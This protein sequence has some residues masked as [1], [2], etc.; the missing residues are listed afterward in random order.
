MSIAAA[1]MTALGGFLGVIGI[2]LLWSI[3]RKGFVTLWAVD[4]IR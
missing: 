2:G 1:L 4:A 3:R